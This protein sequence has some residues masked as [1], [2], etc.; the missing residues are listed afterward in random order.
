MTCIVHK[1]MQFCLYKQTK[2]LE[3]C[4]RCGC[5]NPPF[6]KP[7]KLPNVNCSKRLNAVYDLVR[8]GTEQLSPTVVHFK[9]FFRE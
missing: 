4:L 8:D 6:K 9:T 2:I 1:V 3:F 7:L 5:I